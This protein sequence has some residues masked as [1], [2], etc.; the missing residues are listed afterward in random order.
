MNSI[1][2]LSPAPGEKVGVRGIA[3]ADKPSP[4]PSPWKGEGET[5]IA[6]QVAEPNLFIDDPWPSTSR[7]SER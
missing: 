4:L 6:I 3:P 1:G 5:T 7:A 2:S